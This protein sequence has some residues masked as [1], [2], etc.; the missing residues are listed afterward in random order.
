MIFGTAVLKQ[1]TLKMIKVKLR[2]LDEAN[3]NTFV[4]QIITTWLSASGCKGLF[5]AIP[6]VFSQFLFLSVFSNYRKQTQKT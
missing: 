3:E 5:E 4:I 6:R 2:F 1:T